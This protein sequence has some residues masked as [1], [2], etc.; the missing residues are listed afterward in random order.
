MN[1]IELEPGQ[2][3]P[4]QGTRVLVSIVDYKGTRTE[5]VVIGCGGGVFLEPIT[6]RAIYSRHVMSHGPM[7]ATHWCEIPPLS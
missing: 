6:D 2:P 7:I 3:H 5:A 4:E 1:W